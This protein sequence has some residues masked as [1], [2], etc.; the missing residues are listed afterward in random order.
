MSNESETA[1]WQVAHSAARFLNN[2]DSAFFESL[3][4]S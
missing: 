2:N 3:T 4:K 1:D